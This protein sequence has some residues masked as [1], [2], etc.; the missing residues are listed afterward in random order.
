VRKGVNFQNKKQEANP[1][2]Q[3]EVHAQDPWRKFVPVLG[4]ESPCNIRKVFSK[5]QDVNIF[6]VTGGVIRYLKKRSKHG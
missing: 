3:L 2:N 5:V 1:G 6:P 4:F